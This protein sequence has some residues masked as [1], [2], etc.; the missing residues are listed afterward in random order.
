MDKFVIFLVAPVALVFI[1]FLDIRNTKKM[2]GIKKEIEDL[3]KELERHN[4]SKE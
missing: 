3:K 4:V 2:K 1:A